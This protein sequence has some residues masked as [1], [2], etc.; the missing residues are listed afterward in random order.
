MS[1]FLILLDIITFCL[2][3]STLTATQIKFVTTEKYFVLCYI[4][5]FPGPVGKMGPKGVRVSREV[6]K[7]TPLAC[8]YNLM[9]GNKRFF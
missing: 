5:G 9:F 6:G 8:Y 4:Q 7:M 3:F 1:L 2:C